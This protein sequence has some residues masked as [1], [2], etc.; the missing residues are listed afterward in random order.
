MLPVI[1]PPVPASTHGTHG[2]QGTQGTPATSPHPAGP[3]KF[4]VPEVPIYFDAL[5]VA[6]R[7][8]GWEDMLE[9]AVSRWV[10]A[11]VDEKRGER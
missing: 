8:E 11:L 10:Q 9:S 3:Q 1:T 4:S 2:A 5:L 6:R 7:D